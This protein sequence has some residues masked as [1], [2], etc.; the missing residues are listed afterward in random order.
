MQF[1]TLIKLILEL[2]ESLSIRLVYPKNPSAEG[3]GGADPVKEWDIFAKFPDC[4]P[5]KKGFSLAVLCC[6]RGSKQV[7]CI[8][9]FF[10]GD[11]SPSSPT[12]GREIS[13]VSFW[14]IEVPVDS[15]IV[16]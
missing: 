10:K 16:C 3:T 7:G 6:E 8:H 1:K 14:S 2:N 9:I 13:S 12:Q 4:S 15:H 5:Y 11:N